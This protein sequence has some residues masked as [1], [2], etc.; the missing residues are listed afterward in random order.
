[1]FCMFINTVYNLF[2]FNPASLILL[3]LFCIAYVWTLRSGC[4]KKAIN[5]SS[6]HH[7]CKGPF[8]VFSYMYFQIFTISK[9]YYLFLAYRK[10][11]GSCPACWDV[12]SRPCSVY[13]WQVEPLDRWWLQHVPLT[14]RVGRGINVTCLHF[15][16]SPL[17]DQSIKLSICKSC[18]QKVK[19]NA[20]FLPRLL[21]A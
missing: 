1:M 18:L 12:R 11:V 17:I 21:M 2:C 7:C 5:H 14:S 15:I 9:L 10:S 4:G 20:F 3:N 8:Q 13:Q 6:R 19:K 16:M